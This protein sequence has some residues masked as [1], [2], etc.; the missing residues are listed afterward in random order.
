VWDN[1]IGMGIG[2]LGFG[3][4]AISLYGTREIR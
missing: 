3:V 2:V 1:G 4:K